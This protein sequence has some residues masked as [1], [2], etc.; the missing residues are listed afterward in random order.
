MGGMNVIPIISNGF[1]FY[2]PMLICLLCVGTYFRLGSRCLHILGVRQFFDDDEVSAEY[3]EDGKNLM[4][5]GYFF[6]RF[7]FY[8]KNKLKFRKKKLWRN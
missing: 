3:I 8:L 7:F 1:N 4:K 2:F 5:R 6:I